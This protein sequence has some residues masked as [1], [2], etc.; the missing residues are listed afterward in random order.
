[1]ALTPLMKHALGLFLL[2]DRV[3]RAMRVRIGR[4]VGTDGQSLARA[5]LT[6]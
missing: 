6:T 5:C 1:M 2:T 3:R 4:L